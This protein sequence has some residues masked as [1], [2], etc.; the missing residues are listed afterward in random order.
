MYYNGYYTY[1]CVCVCAYKNTDTYTR[2]HSQVY[3]QAQSLSIIIVKYGILCAEK[4]AM[5][6][7]MPPSVARTCRRCHWHCCCCSRASSLCRTVLLMQL[8]WR[9]FETAIISPMRWIAV[10][11][12]QTF[13][14][15]IRHGQDF[16]MSNKF[17]EM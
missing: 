2:T 1:I 6:V 7:T 8:H 5:G 10:G 17:W 16:Q 14:P 15:A 4:Y 9:H 12:R 3:V 11:S 13:S